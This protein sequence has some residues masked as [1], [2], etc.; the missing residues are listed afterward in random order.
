MLVPVPAVLQNTVVLYRRTIAFSYIVS[1][2]HSKS[3]LRIQLYSVDQS[4]PP[5]GIQLYSVDQSQ[6]EPVAHASLM[7][8][9]RNLL[10]QKINVCKAET[11]K[12]RKE[13][14]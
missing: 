3:R 8:G 1:T 9:E 7:I 2:N 4:E 5:L 10:N 14:V 13:K 12:E 6:Q 11:K